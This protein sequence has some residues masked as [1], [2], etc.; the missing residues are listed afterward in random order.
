MFENR[1]LEFKERL[2]D[3]FLKTVTAFA[4]YEGGKIIFGMN[5]HGVAIGLDENLED[6]ALAVEN[7]IN[8]TIHPQPCY[9]LEINASERLVTLTVHPGTDKPYYYKH[10]S[11]RRN[12]TS[13]IEVDRLELSRLIL[14]GQNRAYEEISAQDQALTFKKLEE[15]LKEVVG[16]ERLTR[17]IERT[18]QL[19][20]KKD[21]YNNAAAIL[22]DNNPFPGVDFAKIGEDIN[23]FEKRE[24]VHHQ[25]I[26]EVYD[27][28]MALFK[29]YYIY[30]KVEGATRQRIE[31]IPERAFREA[32]A[33]AL[34][35]RTWDTKEEI[36][37]EAHDRFIQITSPGGLPSGISA[38]EYLAGR[39]SVLRNPILADVFYRLGLVEKFGTGILRILES[40]TGCARQPSFAITEHTVSMTLPLIEKELH[41][42]EDE[43]AIYALL[44]QHIGRSMGEI[45]E[46]VSFGRSKIR[47]ILNR[48]V[49]DRVVRVEGRGRGTKYFKI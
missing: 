20:T 16:I 42:G 40:Y 22:A 1:K 2:T 26:L 41:L 45:A 47:S 8:D 11:Y 25:S 38:E 21:G 46:Q 35:H 4:N 24:T 13:T 49:E 3:T 29:D 30:E 34:V 9:Q 48:L 17:D 7:K 28:I 36:R 23:I 32:L 27:R 43:R 6:F 10:K 37:V 14:E 33:N 19:Y 5:D 12:D 18:L 31:R 15:K 39:L 44:N